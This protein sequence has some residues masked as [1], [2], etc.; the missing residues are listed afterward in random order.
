[1]SEFED[2]RYPVVLYY[3]GFLKEAPTEYLYCK[4]DVG[5]SSKPLDYQVLVD[6]VNMDK[7]YELFDPVDM[8]DRVEF[9]TKEEYEAN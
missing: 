5:K 7:F 2:I 6:S 3:K 8:F 4:V 9:V 1:M